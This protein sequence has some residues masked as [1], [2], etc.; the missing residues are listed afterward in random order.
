[1][2][3][4]E[5]IESKKGGGSVYMPYL[6]MGDPSYE[7]TV[8]YALGMIDAGADLLEIGIPFS[9]PT[10][11]GPVI[12]EAMV[13]SLEATE[14]SMDKV[15]EAVSKIHAA[16]PEVPIVFL[17]YMNPILN[18]F[19]ESLEYGRADLTKPI[20][21][22]LTYDAPG[23]IEV[24]LKRCQTSGVR[25]LVVPDL[26]FDSPESQVL[27]ERGAELGVDQILLVAPNTTPERL[28]GICSAAR[29][30]IY[31]VT[32]MGVTG[33]RAELPPDL[34]ERIDLVK[35]KSGLPVFAG[36][37]FSDPEQARSLSG[38][39]DGIIVG[40]LNH[41]IIAEHGVASD[42]PLIEITRGFAEACHAGA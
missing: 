29:G 11:D 22:R 42:G 30:F 1:M 6:T 23:A 5:Y 33:M 34:R 38:S 41:R 26:P 40:S 31:Y 39:V 17:S 35:E 37:G 2:K 12:Q 13:R 7:K 20:G 27:R 32:S 28:A 24:F 8:E 19:A 15:F 18:G 3:L 36:F 14:F 4:N 10:A 25:G 21:Q 16:R 9:D